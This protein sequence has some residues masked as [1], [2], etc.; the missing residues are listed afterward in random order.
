[1]AQARRCR[2]AGNRKAGH[3]AES[4]RQVKGTNMPESNLSRRDLLKSAAG[5]ALLVPTQVL[6]AND[7]ITFGVIGVGGM[8]TGHVGSL[9]R[10]SEVDNIRVAAVCDVYRR[11][12]TRAQGIS[13]GEGY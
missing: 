5:A 2:R 13:K 9:V 4:D 10:R 12:I 7:R 11:R 6:G 8:G 3:P 1:M